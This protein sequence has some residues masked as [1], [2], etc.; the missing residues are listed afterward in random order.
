M[1]PFFVTQLNPSNIITQRY[2]KC[3]QQ[4]TDNRQET[5]DNM[6]VQIA[7]LG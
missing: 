2:R 4:I 7:I 3:F 5:T 1:G 6:R